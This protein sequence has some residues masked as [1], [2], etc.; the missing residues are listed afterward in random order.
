VVLEERKEKREEKMKNVECRTARGLDRRR[1]APLG[2]SYPSFIILLGKDKP[3]G[4]FYL[5]LRPT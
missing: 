5:A 4:V 2:S 3:H 1:A